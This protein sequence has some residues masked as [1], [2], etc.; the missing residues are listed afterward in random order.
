MEIKPN[1][2]KNKLIFYKQTFKYLYY[3]LQYIFKVVKYSCT[4]IVPPKY[5]KKGMFKN[6]YKDFNDR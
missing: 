2:E 5:L 6:E 4:E 3:Y 1:E